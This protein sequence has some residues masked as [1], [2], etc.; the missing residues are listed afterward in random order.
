MGKGMSGVRAWA[1]FDSKDCLSKRILGGYR[2]YQS[3]RLA[4]KVCEVSQDEGIGRV[5][6]RPIKPKRRGKRK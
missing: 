1:V 3:K 6:I 2:I 4:K 5:E